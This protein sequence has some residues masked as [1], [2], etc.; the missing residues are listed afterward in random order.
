M[1]EKVDWTS[2]TRT[3]SAIY[4]GDTI[5]IDKRSPNYEDYSDEILKFLDMHAGSLARGLEPVSL[6]GDMSTTRFM[7]LQLH[8]GLP[9]VFIHQGSCEHLIIIEQI[10]LFH[11]GDDPRIVNYPRQVFRGGPRRLACSICS[12]KLARWITFND[13]EAPSSPCMFCF[14]CFFM[15]H[16]SE[17][18][19]PLHKF[20][21]YVYLENLEDRVGYQ[22]AL[23][24]FKKTLKPI[25]VKNE[26]MTLT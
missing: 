15:L 12:D 2:K 7:D 11:P 20:N 4:L 24:K 16:Y 21:A 19:E 17:R 10:R 22:V 6:V 25:S 3:S 5:Y 14:E 1:L 23:E 8:L 18:H 13:E 9:Y 26:I